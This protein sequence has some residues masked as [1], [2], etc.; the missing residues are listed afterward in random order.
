MPWALSSLPSS[1]WLSQLLAAADVSSLGEVSL[2]ISAE[3]K[4]AWDSHLCLWQK[5][6]V[7]IFTNISANFQNINKWIDLEHSLGQRKV[8]FFLKVLL[9]EEV[10]KAS[11]NQRLGSVMDTNIQKVL[12]LGCIQTAKVRWSEP[13]VWSV[14]KLPSLRQLLAR[15]YKGGQINQRKKFTDS[16]CLFNWPV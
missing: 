4:W 15:N 8:F 12:F 1:D 16:K 14:F 10:M 6:V 13:R 5:I 7:I 11:N 3:W 9:Y 2:C